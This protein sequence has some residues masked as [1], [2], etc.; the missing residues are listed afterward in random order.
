[1]IYW[2]YLKY[3]LK[4]KYFVAKEC[5]K[6]GL[7]L[8][9]FT[10]DLSKFLPSEFI[11]YAYAFYGTDEEKKAY[12]SKY[13]LAWLKHQKRNPHH[14]QY[15]LLNNDLEQPEIICMPD[16][17]ILEMYCDWVGAGLAI[18]GRNDVVEWY[19]KIKDKIILHPEAKKRVESLIYI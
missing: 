6:R 16:K 18:S 15:W 14:W 1:M 5:F 19:S 9:G 2:K 12:N 3:L 8:Q 13:I 7:W 11:P 4:H 17:Y 10:H